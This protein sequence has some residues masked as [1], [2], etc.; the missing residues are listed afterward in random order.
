M[1]N[2]IHEVISMNR[3]A[4]ADLQEH[5]L[6]KAV[7][8]LRQAL[9]LVRQLSTE[10][11][12]ESS[13]PWED[14]SPLF[15]MSPPS[16]QPVPVVGKTEMMENNHKYGIGFYG[17]A[18]EIRLSRHR[19]DNESHVTSKRLESRSFTT[20]VT[21]VLDMC[22]SV[23]LYN[24]AL[25]YHQAG[26]KTRAE[27]NYSL[28]MGYFEKA[29]KLYA[30]AI[31]CH[32]TPSFLLTLQSSLSNLHLAALNNMAHVYIYQD[33]DDLLGLC[34]TKFQQV[35]DHICPEAPERLYQE[36]PWY[37]FFC[38]SQMIQRCNCNPAAAA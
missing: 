14:A 11:S 18:I 3:N 24:L 29:A 26:C 7:I 5:S 21:E 2:A 38:T 23:I 12:S 20:T 33:Q 27:G 17:Y 31:E 8:L 35:L 25:I 30:A 36:H 6:T 32:N 1:Y 37:I 10:E 13:E 19:S 9:E 15:T 4:I 22:T 16:L 28:K 34:L